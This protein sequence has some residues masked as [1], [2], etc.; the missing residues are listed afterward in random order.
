[1]EP[2]E[3]YSAEYNQLLE[4]FGDIL[5]VHT[6]MEFARKFANNLPLTLAEKITGLEA[7]QYLF[8]PESL[9]KTLAYYK[10]RRTKGGIDALKR[11]TPEDI[12]YL[13]SLGIKVTRAQT[14]KHSKITISTK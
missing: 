5:Q 10:W 9:H 11:I 6:V 13:Q 8:P 4:R 12:A 14:G 1:M 3:I 2:D 7:K